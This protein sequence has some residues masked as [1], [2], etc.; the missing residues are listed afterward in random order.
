M[1]YL[2][3]VHTFYSNHPVLLFPILYA[4]AYGLL[5][6]TEYF[7]ISYSKWTYID[8]KAVPI[9]D[10][11]FPGWQIFSFVAAWVF[12]FSLPLVWTED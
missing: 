9:Y 12:F 5:G 3:K 8:G 7:H 6:I 2:K 11:I 1:I 4:F 10:D